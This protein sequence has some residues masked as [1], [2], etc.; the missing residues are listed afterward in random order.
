MTLQETLAALRALAPE[1]LALPHDP[2][3]LLVGSEDDP[4]PITKI[5]VCLDATPDACARAASLGVQ[6]VVCH[7]PLIYTP[8][9]RIDAHADP[10][11][12]AVAALVKGDISLYAM[13]TNWDRAS[14]GVNDC[15]ADLLELTDVHPLGKDGEAALPRIG[16]LPAPCPP[17][18]FAR[19]VERTLN[20][21]GTNALRCPDPDSKAMISRVAVCGG[22]GAPLLRAALAAGAD[23][24]VTSD[25]RH[26]EFL[27]ARALG[28]LLV[29][30][31]HAATETPAM[32]DLCQTLNQTLP[33]VEAV[34]VGMA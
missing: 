1:E 26:H 22:A 13:H 11:A 2:I 18:D 4:C 16:T 15:L 27:E 19:L 29:D 25:V 8:L 12:R 6:L 23:A 14:G 30:A 7:H 21:T 24:Y 10:V 17:A 9:K 33:G 32:R 28:L 34:W 31:G 3:G 20:C 5:G